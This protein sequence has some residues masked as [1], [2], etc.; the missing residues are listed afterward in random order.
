MP[1]D[2]SL[3]PP[4][5]LNFGGTKVLVVYQ[6]VSVTFNDATFFCNK[7]II[8]VILQHVQFMKTIC[9][10]HFHRLDYLC[11]TKNEPKI[12]QIEILQI[13]FQSDF[14]EYS[15]K[16]ST[17][18]ILNYHLIMQQEKKYWILL[19][20]KSQNYVKFGRDILFYVVFSFH[21]LNYSNRFTTE[22][23][24][25]EFCTIPKIAKSIHAKHTGTNF[26]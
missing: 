22:I 15:I 16:Q 25:N 14:E 13:F 26:K 19:K 12:F 18:N 3:S 8:L 11:S 24:I 1:C 6:I 10:I 4:E 7:D 2:L 20:K 5:A 17:R 9:K 21:E 23:L